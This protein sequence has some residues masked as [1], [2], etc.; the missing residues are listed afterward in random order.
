MQVNFGKFKK[1]AAAAGEYSDAITIQASK[2]RML[3]LSEADGNLYCY[4]VDAEYAMGDCDC[5]FSCSAAEIKDAIKDC[6]SSIRKM[7]VRFGED[8]MVLGVPTKNNGVE[9]KTILA[10]E[11]ES[12]KEINAQM[13]PI[14][15]DAFL[16]YAKCASYA[17]DD[18]VP[19]LGRTNLIWKE[20]KLSFV[21]YGESDLSY[22]TFTVPDAGHSDMNGY[23][24]SAQMKNAMKYLRATLSEDLS[25]GQENGSLVLAS[26]NETVRIAVRSQDI[27]LPALKLPSF[28]P[29]LS[30]ENEDDRSKL[31]KAIREKDASVPTEILEVCRDF[32]D[33]KNFESGMYNQLLPEAI[34]IGKSYML[35]IHRQKGSAA[36]TN[37][38]IIG[39]TRHEV[40][41]KEDP[42]E[43]HAGMDEAFSPD[44]ISEFAECAGDRK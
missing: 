4:G 24:P 19:L 41:K 5:S 20:G 42:A 25:V 13:T 8:T 40:P 15:L 38:Q 34:F 1:G 29:T 16:S 31:F 22:V 18:A 14:P 12:I 39:R 6:R 43:N 27:S 17:E 37:V 9:D 21:G 36:A 44:N 32:G 26:G 3:F 30:M 11:T 33:R 10:A 2:G 23:I 28:Q 7:E 35:F